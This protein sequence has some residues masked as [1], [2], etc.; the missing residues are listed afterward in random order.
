MI[1]KLINSHG[2][3]VLLYVTVATT[4]HDSDLKSFNNAYDSLFSKVFHTSDKA[5]IKQCQYYNDF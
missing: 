2:V 5:V 3:S 1:L 4:L